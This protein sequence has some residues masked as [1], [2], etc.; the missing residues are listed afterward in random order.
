MPTSTLLAF[1]RQ[2]ARGISQ[3]DVELSYRP[4]PILADLGRAG[5]GLALTIAP[6]FLLAPPWPVAAGLVGL[7]ALFAVFLHQTW[8]R[9]RTRIL[10]RLD[11]IELTGASA[12]FLAWDDLDRLRLRWFGRHR[13]GAGWLDLELRG[14]GSRFSVTSSLEG[15]ELV[16]QRALAAAERN[17]VAIEPLTRANLAALGRAARQ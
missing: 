7:A 3:D 14:G 1:A 4:Y 12:R 5:A 9:S 16:L 10:L 2:P 17:G 15:F 11:G 6:L 13:P 8:Q